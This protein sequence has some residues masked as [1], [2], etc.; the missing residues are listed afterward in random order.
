MYLLIVELSEKKG[1]IANGFSG[2][3]RLRGFYYW[4]QAFSIL[5]IGIFGE[6]EK[7]IGS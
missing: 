1:C 5:S 6:E 2:F 7:A 3:L 4:M